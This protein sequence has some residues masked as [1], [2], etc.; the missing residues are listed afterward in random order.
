MRA[1]GHCRM[2]LRPAFVR[3]L[4]RHHLVAESWFLKQPV[5]LRMV[6]NA[7]ANIV[8]LCRACHDLIDSRESDVRYRERKMLRKRLSQSEIAFI[9]QVRGIKWLNQTYPE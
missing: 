6:R 9:I 4:T 7:H 2:C 5:H 1:E 3:P 8:P